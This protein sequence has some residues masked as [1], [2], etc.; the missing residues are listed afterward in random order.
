M[1]FCVDYQQLNSVTKKD[2]YALTRID[3]LLDQ[4]ENSCFFSTLELAAGY[5]QICMAPEAHKKTAF[6]THQ[7]LYEF[8]VMPFGL[9]NAPAAFQHLMQQLL[10]HLT[11]KGGAEFVNVYIDNVIVFSSSLE[12]HLE[13]LRKVVCKLMEAGLKLKPSKCHFARGEVEYFGFLV[14]RDTV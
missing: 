7:G 1:R 2:T 8:E 11:P 12:D 6:V 13:H 5:W 9:T 14:T 4:L 3:D 10:L